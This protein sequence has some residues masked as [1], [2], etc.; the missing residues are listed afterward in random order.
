MP[1]LTLAKT[2]FETDANRSFSYGND[3]GGKA[4]YVVV[5]NSKTIA[6]S[7]CFKVLKVT[8]GPTYDLLSTFECHKEK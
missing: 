3:G 6:T 7:S 5:V 8:A 1:S 4:S 2:Y